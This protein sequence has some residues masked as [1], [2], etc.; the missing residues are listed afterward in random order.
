MKKYLIL[1]VTIHLII[2]TGLMISSNAG[3]LESKYP[4]VYRVNLVGAAVPPMPKSS[5]QTMQ[6]SKRSKTVL[7]GKP[8]PKG[9]SLQQKNKL[10]KRK[11]PAKRKLEKKSGSSAE[12]SQ[13]NYPDFL[14]DI[15]FGSEFG[16]IKI[17]A[18]GFES[19]YYVNLIFAKIR[20][21]WNNPIKVANA[22]QATVYFRV[23]SDGTIEDVNIETS[24]GIEIFDQAALRA[25]LTSSP[26]PPLPQEFRGDNIGIHLKFEYTP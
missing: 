20:S 9:L 18:A 8:Q 1:S 4:K 19:S 6:T 17:D 5:A 12:K 21:R 11:N 26:L 24:S 14:D 7:R 15:D 23:N 3:S 13:S 25:I 16:G 22:L 2:L 10:D